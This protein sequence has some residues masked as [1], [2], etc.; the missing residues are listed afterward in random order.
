MSVGPTP[1][2][3][4]AE[5]AS[6][7]DLVEG[8]RAARE[9]GYKRVE[10]YSPYPIKELDEILPMTNLLPAVVLGAGVLGALTAFYMQYFI[11]AI[12]YPLN[13]GGRPL[14]SWPE[15]IPIIF[16]LTV[17]FASCAAFFGMLLFAGFP[18]PYHA[19]FRIPNFKRVSDDGFFLCIEA[20]DPRFDPV[21]T[22]RFLQSLEPVSVWEVD[23][24]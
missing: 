5:F 7:D 13:I 8:A 24:E 17:L 20:R 11:A 12:V 2:G 10:A 16:E 15:W 21:D 1:Y 18:A 14:N 9:R 4:A 6:P 3:V 23:D 19:L 22:A